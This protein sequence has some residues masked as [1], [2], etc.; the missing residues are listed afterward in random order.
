MTLVWDSFAD[1]VR[2]IGSRV[3]GV[4]MEPKSFKH[5][6][7]DAYA[8]QGPDYVIGAACAKDA[9]K[10]TL[11]P[12]ISKMVALRKEIL[13]SGRYFKALVVVR[14]NA[15]SQLVAIAE[16]GG[17]LVLS[18]SSFAAM[19]IEYDKYFRARQAAPFGSAVDPQTGEIDRIAY[20]PVQYKNRDFGKSYKASE[21][22]DQILSGKIVVLLGEYGSGKSRCIAE[23]Y[24]ELARRWG[25]TLAF[26]FAVNLRECW[27]MQT[28][29][30][31]LRRHITRL[32]LDEIESQAVRVFRRHSGTFLLDG[33]DEMGS[34]A[35][36]ADEDKLRALRAVALQGVRD[37]VANSGRGCLIAGREHYF[38]SFEEMVAALGLNQ[39]NLLLLHV[40]EEFTVEQMEDY[41]E[42][43]QIHVA[44]PNWLPRRP[45]ICQTIAQL[46]SDDIGRMFSEQSHEAEF[47]EYFIKVVCKRDSRINDSFDPDIILAV[48]IELARQSRNKQMTVGPFS[49]RDLQMAF[50]TAVGQP[51]TEDASVMLQR[52]PSL[53]RI[54]A[55]STDRQFVDMYILD[56]LRARDIA[57]LPQVSEAVRSRALDEQWINPLG[58]LGQRVLALHVARRADAFMSLMTRASTALNAVLA[59]DLASS[60]LHTGSPKIDFGGVHIKGAVFGNINFE[61]SE[62]SKLTISESVIE[63]LVLPSHAPTSVSILSSSAGSVAGVSSFEGLPSWAKLDSVDEFDSV[64][65]VSKIRVAGLDMAHEILVAIIKKIFFQKGTGRKEDALLRGFGSGA[66]SKMA[67]KILNL[68]VREDILGTFK[69]D[70]GT[71]YTPVRS[72]A[73]RMHEIL[74]ELRASNDPLWGTVGGLNRD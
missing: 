66:S 53:G 38:S 73:G 54:G 41:F 24:S 67:S 48:Y 59:A 20:V 72:Q 31:I 58:V 40:D 14:G 50:E 1:Q 43:A 10:T 19:L 28:G 33:F 62:A 44:L 36:S 3:F 13:A 7:L 15:S 18:V 63:Q 23:V 61:L 47:W 25:D 37:I 8:E 71:V 2:D 69:G 26:P 51:P 49:L 64:Q 29:E 21:I 11:E 42:A 56:G 65:T 39:T 34:Q 9:N 32:S 30:E 68:L 12:I 45:L 55:E 22:A 74:N 27:G 17:V 16:T 4:S 60:F 5:I 35:W 6:D 70:E 52:L 57:R 46:E